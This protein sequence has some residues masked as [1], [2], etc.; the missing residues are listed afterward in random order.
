MNTLPEPAARAL[1]TFIQAAVG[2]FLMLVIVPH[3]A[4]GY[5]PDFNTLK[6][7]GIAALFAGGIALLSFVQN[8]AEQQNALPAFAKPPTIVHE[9][10][11]PVIVT[12][13]P[14]QNPVPPTAG[15]DPPLPH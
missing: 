1:R 9:A 4:P 10:P 13:S 12:P 5:V 8:W 2:T 7:A 15:G 14:G 11:P 6:S 3:A